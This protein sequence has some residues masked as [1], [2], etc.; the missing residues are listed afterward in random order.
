[1]WRAPPHVL[2]AHQVLRLTL[3]HT[4]L[5]LGRSLTHTPP[6]GRSLT[7]FLVAAPQSYPEGAQAVDVYGRLALHYAV[8]K[9]RSPSPCSLPLL[10]A[11]PPLALSLSYGPPL[12]LLSPSLTPASP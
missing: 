11:A 12:P 4:P 1:M 7:H 9:V 3:A 5:P 10:R 2:T 6:P 8:D